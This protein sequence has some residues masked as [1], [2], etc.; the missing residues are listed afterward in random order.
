ML[1][2]SEPR[3]FPPMTLL[4]GATLFRA[5]EPSSLRVID[6]DAIRLDFRSERG[7]RFI[8]RDVPGDRLGF[9]SSGVGRHRLTA[10]AVTPRRVR[11]LPSAPGR[12]IAKLL[13]EAFA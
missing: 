8:H 6:S 9:E 12:T 13:S 2:H 1:P 7:E 5:A 4:P 10:R 11:P 3:A